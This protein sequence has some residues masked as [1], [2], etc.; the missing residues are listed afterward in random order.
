MRT[1]E[2]F[3]KIVEK[4]D[5]K[6]YDKLLDMSHKTLINNAWEIAEWQN[7]YGYMKGRVI[8]YLK[9]GKNMFEDFL[10]LEIDNPIATTCEFESINYDEAQWTTWDNLDL[11]VREMFRAIKNQNN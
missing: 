7:I 10:T 4:E 9:D 5:E 2:E 3:V 8:P 11:V 6:Y 1:V